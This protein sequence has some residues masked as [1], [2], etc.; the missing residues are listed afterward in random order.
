MPF[1]VLKKTFHCVFRL[2]WTE[3]KTTEEV[4]A[5]LLWKSATGN[6]LPASA[7]SLMLVFFGR[8]TAEG[9]VKVQRSRL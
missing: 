5:D 8:M 7:T 2:N 6:I 9:I 4:E 3:K 1:V